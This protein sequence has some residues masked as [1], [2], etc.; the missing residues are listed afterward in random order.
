MFWNFEVGF[1]Q[2]YF[3]MVNDFWA[4]DI[5]DQN[6]TMLHCAKAT[7]FTYE[8]GYPKYTYWWSYYEIS[9]YWF[10]NR[11]RYSLC[12]VIHFASTS[13]KSKFPQFFIVTTHYS[14][15]TGPGLTGTKGAWSGKGAKGVAAPHPLI[16]WR[17]GR[18]WHSTMEKQHLKHKIKS[19]KNQKRKWKIFI[20]IK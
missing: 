2:V 13:P 4:C 12:P 5:T 6:K 11:Y 17:G 16:G 14:C 8:L 18:S 19:K 3:K 20:L 7:T 9:T 10:R 1:L 15:V